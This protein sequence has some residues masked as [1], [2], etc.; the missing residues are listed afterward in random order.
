MVKGKERTK[1]Q[2][3]E[4]IVSL[5]E[6]IKK[7]LKIKPRLE[8]KKDELKECKKT[9]ENRVDSRTSAERVI[10]RLLHAEIDQRKQLV[11]KI[12]DALEY[13]NGIVN[14]IRDPLIILDADLKVISASRSFYQTFKVKPEDTERQY[15]YDLGD[16]QWNIPKLRELLEDILPHATSFDDFEVEHEFPNI[17]KRIMLLNA[18][19]IYR[20]ANHT[21]LILLA[22]EDVTDYKKAEEKLKILASHDELTGCLNFRSIMEVIE[23]E[24]IRSRRY[25]KKFSIIMIDIDQLKVINDEYSHTAGNDALI[26]FADVIKNSVRNI[27]VI[28]RY[29]GDE[30][31]VI[32]PETDSQNALV[33]L[34]R[35][36][37]GLNQTK[38]FSPQVKNLNKVILTFSA[39]IA[40]FPDNAKNLKEL[41]C[42]VDGALRRA[43]QEGKNR[44][45]LERRRFI[46]VDPASGV[47]VEMIDFSDKQ[48]MKNLTIIN[49]SEK[50]M[51][52][53]STQDII[54]ERFI[55][56]IYCPKG[57]S[58]F[59]I[60][61]KVKHKTKTGSGLYRIGV[62]FLETPEYLEDKL[63]NCIESSKELD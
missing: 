43:K 11:Q 54:D 10:S 55:C 4:I 58:P 63:S 40:V 18:R 6:Q 51:L 46:R 19:K 38:I 57:G 62:Y 61:C 25:Q 26:A 2:L 9:F 17:G 16:Y 3:T 35:I 53:L 33:A 44:T 34:E 37:L 56:R 12:E 45:V 48:N 32:L 47:R 29:G 14:T 30:F 42:V 49:L 8:K 24:I 39:G 21:Q 7:P 27:D 1:R 13:A 52:L 20:E 28:G 23:N 5:H 60:T 41:I 59:E 15:I 50:G 22:I 36:K 31:I